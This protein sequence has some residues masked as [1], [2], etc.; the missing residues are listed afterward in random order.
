M[1]ADNRYTSYAR[2]MKEINEALHPRL[3][4]LP[5]DV[6][7]LLIQRE[8]LVRRMVK[9]LGEVLEDA[10]VLADRYVELTAKCRDWKQIFLEPLYEQSVDRSLHMTVDINDLKQVLDEMG[11][12]G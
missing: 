7:A 9:D 4:E 12:F 10:C 5:A 6:Q 3:E 11:A 1:K 2:M 8:A